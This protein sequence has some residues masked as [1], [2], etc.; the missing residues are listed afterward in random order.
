M[1][2][3]SQAEII[4]EVRKVALQLPPPGIDHLELNPQALLCPLPQCSRVAL[5]RADAL[6]AG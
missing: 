2:A 1:K 6:Y 4:R 5:I 3:R